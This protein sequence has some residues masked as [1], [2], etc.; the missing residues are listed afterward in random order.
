MPKPLFIV[1]KHR[2]GTTLIGNLMINHPNVS[3]VS[4]E[5]HEGIHES[6]FFSYLDG[7]YGDLHNFQNYVEF[8]SVFAN[9]DYFKLC[10]GNFEE[11]LNLYPV[12][13]SDVFRKL[14]DDFAI[15]QNTS[16]WVEKTPN[17]THYIQRIGN[18]YENAKFIG[19]KRDIIDVVRSLL[20]LLKNKKWNIFQRYKTVAKVTV[21]KYLCDREMELLKKRSPS[22][23]VIVQFDEL[24]EERTKTMK[25]IFE[26]L[27]LKNNPVQSDYKKNSSFKTNQ[28]TNLKNTETWLVYFLTYLLL[29]VVPVNILKRLKRPER[30]KSLP[31]WFFKGIKREEL[32]E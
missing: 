7:R 2:S 22:K 20:Y 6:A 28:K 14:M 1:G 4:D 8:L 3:G 15:K 27:D 31:R 23:I 17:H 24:I 25:R 18:Y 32:S 16:F 19:I 13:Y 29:P 12:S 26:F 10:K 5:N 30:F 21:D 9:S 11:F